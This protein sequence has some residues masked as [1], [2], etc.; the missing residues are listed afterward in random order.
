MKTGIRAYLLMWI[1]AWSVAW[2]VGRFHPGNFDI[3]Y[4]MATTALPGANGITISVPSCRG[5]LW[6]EVWRWLVLSIAG[7]ITLAKMLTIVAQSAISH[8][9]RRAATWLGG[10]LSF[11][12]LAYFI[13]LLA[14]SPSPWRTVG[15]LVFYYTRGPFWPTL[16]F[17]AAILI[18]KQLEKAAESEPGRSRLFLTLSGLAICS[19]LIMFLIPL[20]DESRPHSGPASMPVV[21]AM[22]LGGLMYLALAT[23]VAFAVV[24]LAINAVRRSRTKTCI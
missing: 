11:V 12:L 5:I 10:L 22:I 8:N 2:A 16:V 15:L 18:A 14:Y 24:K 9:R 4:C 20:V 17:A 21:M 7:G 19:P 3:S 6:D 23:F 1:A 13:S